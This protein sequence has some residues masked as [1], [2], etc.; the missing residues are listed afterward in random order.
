MVAAFSL[1]YEK[2]VAVIKVNNRQALAKFGLYS[3]T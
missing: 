1:I 2:M 3:I